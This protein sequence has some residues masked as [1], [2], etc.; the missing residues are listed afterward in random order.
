[1]ILQVHG[2]SPE[3]KADRE[4]C[5]IYKTI[6]GLNSR[7]GSNEKLEKLKSLI[8]YLEAELVCM[9]EHRQNLTHRDNKNGFAQLFHGG[10]AELRV[11]S[12]HNTHEGKV[13]GR[14]Q[15]G[16]VA[17]VL[18]GYLIE[19]CNFEASGKDDNGCQWTVMVF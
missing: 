17:M 5:L 8:D 15:E 13:A 3:T 1:M 14:L 2:T 18:Y 10:E 19:Q 6:N 9:N 16:G 7:I 4:V 11:V 12:G